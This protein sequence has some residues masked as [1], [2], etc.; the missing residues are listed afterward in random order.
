MSRSLL[1]LVL[2]ASLSSACTL[3]ESDLGST[4]QPI[5]GGQTVSSSEYPTVVGLE[6]GPGNWFCT[7]T[8]IDPEWVLT[9]AHCVA[10]ETA[11][12]VKVRIDDS[13]ISDTS[14]G[15][16]IEVAE[17]HGHP[18]FRDDAWD[19]D[20]AV[21]KLATPITD[22]SPTP[23]YRSAPP[24]GTDV[25]QVGYGDSDDNGGGAGVLRSLATQNIDCAQVGDPEVQGDRLLCF[26]AT[27]GRTTCYGDSGG[28]TFIGAG[29]GLAVTGVTSGGT[30]DSC[31]GGYD[32]E[33]LVISEID[34]VD[35]YVPVAGDGG[36]DTTPDNGGDADP[37][38][39]TGPDDGSGAA[40]EPGGDL[41]GGCSAAG[42]GGA[43]GLAPLLVG[44]GLVALR[45]RRRY[46]G[47]M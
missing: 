15:Q 44:L 3:E 14:G 37:D 24:A 36:D 2:F 47:S 46:F 8:L 28:P 32:L 18:G 25:I 9:A 45:R 7:G 42:G 21:I 4:Q 35:Q 33:T 29:G 16:E 39:G 6:N 20:I 30:A 41:A 23:V 31:T 38:D 13:D 27:T 10:G 12:G 1:S 19:N 11:A 40:S 17:I 26:D 22:R 43:G 34:F 5:I